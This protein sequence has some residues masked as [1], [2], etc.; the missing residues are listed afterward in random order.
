[1]IPSIRIKKA[2]LMIAAIAMIS[3]MACSEKIDLELDGMEPRLVI[4]ARITDLPEGNRVL[5]TKST[6]YN[7][8]TSA[9][10]MTGAVVR[11]SAGKSMW[12]LKEIENGE[13]VLPGYFRG[14]APNVYTIEVDTGKEIVHAV[15]EMKEA[16]QLDSISVRPHPW[17]SD[18]H[19]LVVHFQDPPG[20]LNYYMWKIYKNGV[21]LTDTMRKVAFADSEMFSGRYVRVPVYLLQPEDGIPQ[22]GDTI[23]VD[24]YRITEEYFNFLVATR[25]NSGAAGGPFV[26]PPSNIPSNFSNNALGFFMTAS[27]SSQ[28]RVLD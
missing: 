14:E 2:K 7:A 19:E 5:I 25:R 28:Y 4:D 23:R 24:K 1:M 11:L 16:V 18:H 20:Q 17:L 26:G 8:D 15:S 3:M 21:L 22:P 10:P 6:G 12:H 27:V 9:P 13:Y